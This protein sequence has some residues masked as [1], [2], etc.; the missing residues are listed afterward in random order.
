MNVCVGVCNWCEQRQCYTTHVDL[1]C[2]WSPP[3]SRRR[4]SGRGAWGKKIGAA[5]CSIVA[6]L[7][8]LCYVH[9]PRLHCSTTAAQMK[10]NDSGKWYRQW[11]RRATLFVR[12]CLLW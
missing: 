10:E 8:A 3:F 7:G 6:I 12:R 9:R 2:G 5:C 4:S 1:P 11:L